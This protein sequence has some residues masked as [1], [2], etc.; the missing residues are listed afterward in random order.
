VAGDRVQQVVGRLLLGWV[1]GDGVA[2][3][4]VAAGGQPGR[5]LGGQGGGQPQW[6]AEQEGDWAVEVEVVADAGVA[7]DGVGVGRAGFDA[8]GPVALV[9]LDVGAAD[10]HRVVLDV[11]DA[12]GVFELRGGDVVGGVV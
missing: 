11:G 3:D 8:P 6:I 9:E 1:G 7:Q 5:E 4:Q 12:R 2:D 10:G